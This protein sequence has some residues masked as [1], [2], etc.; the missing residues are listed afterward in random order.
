MFEHRGLA[1]AHATA[2]AVV[3]ADQSDP[4]RSH[5]AAR[6]TPAQD[7]GASLRQAADPARRRHARSGGAAVTRDARAAWRDAARVAFARWG[8]RGTPSTGGDLRRQAR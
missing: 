4:A 6:G 2:R 8:A 3:E 1:S 5:S 7:A